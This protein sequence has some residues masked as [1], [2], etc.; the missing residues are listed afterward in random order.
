LNYSHTPLNPNID[1]QQTETKA[2]RAAKPIKRQL[3]S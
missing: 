1:E 2:Q 3:A